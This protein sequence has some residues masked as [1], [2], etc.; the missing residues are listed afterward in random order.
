MY[1][2]ASYRHGQSPFLCRLQ[3][4]RKKWSATC[5][6]DSDR[7]SSRAPHTC[8]PGCRLRW[9]CSS[10]RAAGYDA[11]GSRRRWLLQVRHASTGTQ[12]LRSAD[13]LQRRALRLHCIGVYARQ[14]RLLGLAGH[15]ASLQRQANRKI[16]SR[17]ERLC[18][19]PPVI[20]FWY[21]N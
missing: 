21:C 17:H 10:G 18:T 9:W 7:K 14:R 1:A 19:Q 6:L 15:A 16:I 12:R 4:Y 3:T 8:C 13:I 20:F 2:T 5:K 11:R